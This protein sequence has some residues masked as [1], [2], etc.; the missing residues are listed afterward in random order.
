MV[1]IWYLEG[2]RVNCTRNALKRKPRY[3]KENEIVECG[4]KETMMDRC[5]DKL[6]GE[7]K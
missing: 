4:E 1:E 5:I 2:E 7:V 6:S 3:K